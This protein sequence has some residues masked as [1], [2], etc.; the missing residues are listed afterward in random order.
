MSR[1]SATPGMRWIRAVVLAGVLLGALLPATG[2]MG[3]E[4]VR[5]EKASDAD[6]SGEWVLVGTIVS[7]R[8]VGEWEQVG[9]EDDPGST[10]STRPVIV[11]CVG[12]DCTIAL[13][14]PTPMGMAA[15]ASCPLVRSGDVWRAD[16][17]CVYEDFDWGLGELAP[18]E[19]RVVEAV[20]TAAGPV[21]TVIDGSLEYPWGRYLGGNDSDHPTGMMVGLVEFRSTREVAPAADEA[22]TTTTISPEKTTTTVPQAGPPTGLPDMAPEQVVTGKEA[23]DARVEGSWQIDGSVVAVEGEDPGIWSVGKP[24]SSV[25]DLDPTC[26]DGPCDVSLGDCQLARSGRTFV[27]VDLCTVDTGVCDSPPPGTA[28]IQFDVVEAVE[29]VDGLQASRIAGTAGDVPF[30]I[31]GKKW[32]TIKME[33]TGVRTDLPAVPSPTSTTIVPSTTTTVPSTTTSTTVAA[34][35]VPGGGGPVGS[36]GWR[37]R[38]HTQ[39]S[40]FP[41]RRALPGCFVAGSGCGVVGDSG[42][43]D[44]HVVGV[45]SGVVDAVPWGVVQPDV[46]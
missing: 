4:T 38:Y 44:Q 46:G 23:A 3:Q 2:A 27:E 34:V 5:G 31:C 37:G 29:T 7:S 12:G 9:P 25:W 18:I 28:P 13:Q 43:G 6:I 16:V 11:E 45:G 30:H 26:T 41:C 42:G 32:T 39:R 40:D 36:G 22:S 24:F 20:T 21:A 10:Q 19:L 8:Q 14:E 1:G 33:Y 15:G 17:I 35:A